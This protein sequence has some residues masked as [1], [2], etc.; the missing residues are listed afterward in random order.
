LKIIINNDL[1]TLCGICESSCLFGAIKI[2]QSIIIMENNCTLCGECERLCPEKALQI[3]T[4]ESNGNRTNLTDYEGVWIFI[5]HDNY[6]IR[7]VSFEILSEGKRLAD[8]INQKLAAVLFCKEGSGFINE[9]IPYGIDTLYIAEHDSLG[10]YRTEIYT[11]VLSNMVLKFKPNILL[12]G[13]TYLGRDLA[14]RLAV[15]LHTG[16]TADCTQLD[17]D[18]Q[19]NLLQVRPTYGGSIMA[20]IVCPFH[21]PQMATVRPNTMIK[22]KVDHPVSVHIERIPLHLSSTRIFT[23]IIGEIEEAKDFQS[24]EEADIVVVGGRGVGSSENFKVLE[25]LA[26]LLGGSVGAS[27]AAVDEGW[28]P[29]QQQ[30]GQTGKTISPKIYIGC[31]VSGAIQHLIGMRT[32]KKIIAINKDKNAPIMKIADIAIVGDLFEF[33]PQLVEY[34][35]KINIKISIRR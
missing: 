21:R 13:A 32:S 26:K 4:K 19:G 14:P 10:H 29:H 9:I 33:V 6:T 15:R 27:R 16:L 5:E 30:V 23:N 7:P 35:K 22:R 34:I 31:G 3:I 28:K 2:D 17:I 18:D 25:E 24:V 1:C 20:S 11:D 12:F 8:K